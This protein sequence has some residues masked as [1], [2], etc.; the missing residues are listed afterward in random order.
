MASFWQYICM[1]YIKQRLY[2]AVGKLSAQG[3]DL[4]DA[5]H[6]QFQHAAEWVSRR[7]PQAVECGHLRAD[8]RDTGTQEPH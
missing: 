1:V 7:L 6:A 2:A 5:V 8:C 4:H 3:L